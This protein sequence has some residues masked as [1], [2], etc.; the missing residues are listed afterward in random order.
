MRDAV[1]AVLIRDIADDVFPPFDAEVGVNIWH[2][3]AFGVEEALEQQ[4]VMNRIDVGDAEGVCHQGASGRTAPRADRNVAIAGVFDVVPHHQ[5]VAGKAHLLHHLH[6]V[7]HPLLVILWDLLAG[8]IEPILQPLP[9]HGF[10][11]A[12]VGMTLGD[13]GMGNFG[14]AQH[15][16]FFDLIRHLHRR[17]QGFFDDVVGQVI[18]EQEPHFVGSF[19]ILRAAVAQALVFSDQLAGLDA[20]QRVVGLDIE[21]G[22]I[23]GIVGGEDFDI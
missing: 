5:E 13:G 21:T 19:Q 18:A 15:F 9:S 1:L 14:V 23:V 8:T 17:F 22:N 16:V 3:L 12:V 4:A 7:V 11:V 2:G 6:F 20:E 10:H